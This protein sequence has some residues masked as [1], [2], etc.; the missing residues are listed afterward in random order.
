MDNTIFLF[1]TIL[2]NVHQRNLQVTMMT[3]NLTENIFQEI[4]ISQIVSQAI[5]NFYHDSII[6]TIKHFIY[7]TIGYE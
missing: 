2:F 1:L 6:H 5:F 3:Y 7:I 4:N